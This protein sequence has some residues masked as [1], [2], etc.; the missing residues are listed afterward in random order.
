MLVCGLHINCGI[1]IRRV[2]TCPIYDVFL[3]SF[4]W[5]PAHNCSDQFLKILDDIKW[6]IALSIMFSLY[7]RV[8]D[9]TP[10]YLFKGLELIITQTNHSHMMFTWSQKRKGKEKTNITLIQI[11]SYLHVPQWIY[12]RF[13][14]NSIIKMW[15]SNPRS[16]FLISFILKTI[17]LLWVLIVDPSPKIH[18]SGLW[19]KPYHD[20]VPMYQLLADELWWTDS[21]PKPTGNHTY[22]LSN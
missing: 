17:Y 7:S 11:Q 4:S 22:I 9:Q 16:S 1:L 8:K 12:L 13:S 5:Y 15:L 21:C 19:A 2:R 20:H 6:L 3:V 18:L 14:Y 10:D